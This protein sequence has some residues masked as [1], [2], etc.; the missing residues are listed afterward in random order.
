MQQ[1][2]CKNGLVLFILLAYIILRKGLDFKTEFWGKKCEN[3]WKSLAN[4]DK[5]R[6]LVVAL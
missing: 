1:L 2:T 4:C 3:V 6:S 5:L